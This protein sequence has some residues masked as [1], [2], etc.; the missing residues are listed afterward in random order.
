MFRVVIRINEV[1]LT[2]ILLP[3]ENTEAGY[4]DYLADTTDGRAV[5]GVIVREADSA[6]RA[7]LGFTGRFSLQDIFGTPKQNRAFLLCRHT[8]N[9]FH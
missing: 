3:S 5:S 2:G 8:I 6:G 1:L 7:R 4:E 9:F